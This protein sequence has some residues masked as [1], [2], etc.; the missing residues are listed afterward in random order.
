MIY[1]YI[2]SKAIIAR[3]E[4][5]YDIDYA[6]WIHNSPMWIAE[7][8]ADLDMLP[9]LE[10][11]KVDLEVEDYHVKLPTVIGSIK[12]I[13]AILYQ[14]KPLDIINQVDPSQHNTSLRNPNRK[15]GYDLY[16][17]AVIKN[18]FITTSFESGTITVFY[19]TFPVEYDEIKQV[20]FPLVPDDTITELAIS[21]YIIYAILRKGHKI[22]DYSLKENNPILNPWLAW[23][24]FK[25]K[26]RNSVGSLDPAAR[27][28]ASKL[29][30]SF[31]VDLNDPIKIE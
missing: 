27:Q 2:S 17:T 16:E 22:G 12:Q 10:D 1:Q 15:E 19:K 30:T 31:L 28:Q 3:V 9:S 13:D 14:N 18:G 7:A 5:D 26:A 29:F 21:W 11:A 8:L 23:E 25:K 20:Y 4:S 24:N 6:D